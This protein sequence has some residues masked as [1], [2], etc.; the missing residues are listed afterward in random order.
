[1]KIQSLQ[2]E[3]SISYGVYE[4]KFGPITIAASNEAVISAKLGK[5]LPEGAKEQKTK[6][7]DKAGSEIIQFLEGK[8][9]EFDLPLNPQGTPF[10]KNVWDALSEIPYGETRSYKEI[11]VAI[12]K[13]K[14]FRAVGMA[15][16][17]N[18]IIFI[19]PCHRVIG[20]NGSLVGYGGG[21]EVKSA[22]LEMERKNHSI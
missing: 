14:A 12:G 21:L 5:Q 4:T 7:T 16:N 15:N 3:P 18:P 8:R 17:K 2:N 22:L 19:I 13:P 9:K 10:Q 11:A 20:A 1:M 6:L